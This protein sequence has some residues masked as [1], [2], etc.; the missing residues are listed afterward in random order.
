MTV[1][2]KKPNATPAARLPEEGE[3]GVP[4]K[5]EPCGLDEHGTVFLH[6]GQAHSTQEALTPIVGLGL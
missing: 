6:S 2:E 1:T 3:A 4:Q 5:C